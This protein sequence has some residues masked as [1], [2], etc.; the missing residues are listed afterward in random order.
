MTIR[1]RSIRLGVIAAVAALALTGCAPGGGGGSAAPTDLTLA[2]SFDFQSFDPGELTTGGEAP[3][4]WMPVYDTLLTSEPDGTLSPGLATSWTYDETNTE[5][6]LELRDDVTFTDGSAFDAEAVKANIEHAAA[7]SGA[8]KWRSASI[9]EVEVVSPTEV[10]FTLAQPDPFLLTNLAFSAG[11][12]G[13]PDALENADIA[14]NPV[15]SGPYTLDTA[16]T[17]VGSSFVYAKNPDYWDAEAW[18]YERITLT[19]IA[20]VTARVNAVKSGQADGAWIDQATSTGFDDARFALYSDPVDWVG[21]NIADRDGTT[22]PALADVRVRQAIAMAFDRQ[23][24]LDSIDGGAGTV[25]EQMWSEGTAAYDPAI[26]GTYPYDPDRAKE[27][28]AEAGYPDGFAVEMADFSFRAKYQP[29]VQKY[30]AAIGITVTYVPINPANLFQEFANPRFTLQIASVGGGAD[31]WDNL[32]TVLPDGFFN[33]FHTSTP[34]LES[35]VEQIRS[36]S[37]AEQVSA[38]QAANRYV[39]DNA[40]VAPWY[41]VDSFYVTSKDTTTERLF[42]SVAPLIGSFAPAS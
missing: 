9:S 40:W 4:Y 15:G 12:I 18:P 30:L 6:T 2:T 22:Q 36:T 20:D 26:E 35:I 38:Y 33:P 16:A 41:K 13:A 27:L 11:A 14:L 31:S 17:T 3:Q 37:D 5:L 7:G 29:I 8:D 24:I 34:E 1:T 10:V 28:L 32:T 25:T 23:A 42:G 39:T 19:V 21:I